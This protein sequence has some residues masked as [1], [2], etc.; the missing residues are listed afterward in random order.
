MH[1]LIDLIIK[2]QHLSVSGYV[3]LKVKE[4]CKHIPNETR[5]L[6]TSALESLGVIDWNK[7]YQVEEFSMS[8]RLKPP[9]A[10][11]PVV[12][13]GGSLKMA[14]REQK[15]AMRKTRDLL[16]N[17]NYPEYAF[18]R[19]I[20]FN[21][22]FKYSDA[23][24]YANSMLRPNTP[25]RDLKDGELSQA[26]YNSLMGKLSDLDSGRPSISLN[27]RV[28]RFFSTVTNLN[29]DY[30]RFLVDEGGQSLISIDFR[31]SHTYHL[32]RW[33]REVV[34]SEKHSNDKKHLD[35]SL[36]ISLLK[37]LTELQQI[38][39]TGGIYEHVRDLYN[40]IN[41]TQIDREKAKSIWIEHFLYGKYPERKVSKW[42][43]SLFP[44]ISRCLESFGRRQVS[45]ELMKSES[46]LLNRKIIRRISQEAPNATIFGIFD[47]LLVDQSHFCRVYEIILTEAY[48]S[49]Q[50][51]PALNVE[52]EVLDHYLTYI[53]QLEV[54]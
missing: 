10:E 15:V 20:I 21:C 47:S 40:L 16:E 5:I 1:F 45:V 4:L 3:N 31:S 2:K 51:V 49:F 18:Q 24:E 54:V 34:K 22:Y 36:C 25:K 26:M 12:M 46:E 29:K 7:K 33:L 52:G 39:E 53:S 17:E 30:R 43:K 11:A 37:E 13:I 44:S 48:Q 28:N 38:L 8:Y 23:V 50:F 27:N 32:V 19:N 35:K 42:V 14:K 6:I 41:H 9:Y